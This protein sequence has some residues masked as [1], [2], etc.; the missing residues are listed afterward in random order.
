MS[1]DKRL[2]DVDNFG[3]T[4]AD[5]DALL[6]EAFEDHRAFESLKAHKRFCVI[7]RKGSGK[8]AIF[9]KF[10][11]HGTWNK[12]A[13]GHTF[14]DYPWHFHE[15]QKSIGV[16]EEQCYVQ[17]W[18]YLCYI[19]IAKLLLNND[20]SQPYSDAAA[21]HLARVERFILDSY[22]TRD[23][24]ITQ[25][26]TPSKTLRFSGEVGINWKILKAGAKI[27]AAPI[28]ELPL[29]VQEVNQ[30]IRNAT[31]ESLNPEIDYYVLFDQLDLGFSLEAKDYSSRMIGLLLAA[32]DINLYARSR[33]KKIT[34]GVFLRD[35]IY[36]RLQFEDKNKITENFCDYVVWDHGSKSNTLKSLMEKRINVVFGGARSKWDEVFDEVHEMSGRQRKYN[37]ILDRTFLR[38]RDM[39]KFCNECL[40][41]LRRSGEQVLKFENK[42]IIGAQATFSDYLQ[43]ELDDEIHKHVPEYR[44]YLEV[45]KNQ[46]SLQFT[47]AEFREVWETR[48]NLFSDGKDPVVAL[49]ELFEFSVVG[50]LALGGGGGGSQYVWKYKDARSQFNEGAAQF[51]VHPGFKEVLGLKKFTRAG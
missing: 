51:R 3:G 4:D 26:F 46:D 48:K 2:D 14:S 30:N 33:G 28:T 5:E 40:N 37:Y 13:F 8:T 32:R 42:H 47:L 11:S 29:I 24:D 21:E 9:K 22:G 6:I 45:I 16:P 39:I 23:P 50:C 36:D 35:D 41:S 34:I 10:L 12:F 1:S 49:R 43:R 17:S 15:K 7:G 25:I 31:I 44:Q 20:N 27:E 19:T 18:Q 38:P